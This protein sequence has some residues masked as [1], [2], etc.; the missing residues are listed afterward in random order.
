MNLEEHVDLPIKDTVA[1]FNLLGME[2]IWSCCGYNYK[3]Q[4]LK[5]VNKDHAQTFQILI[6]A[7]EDTFK[8]I[9]KI[10]NSEI[11]LW[12]GL[13]LN[14]SYRDGQGLVM[15]L[16]RAPFPKNTVGMWKAEDSPHW[17]EMPNAFIYKIN[18][19][20][21]EFRNEF[22]EEVLL[23]DQNTHMK[24]IIPTWEYP[25]SEP[26]LIKKSDVLTNLAGLIEEMEK[27]KFVASGIMVEEKPKL[28]A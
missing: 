10:F 24:K 23:V 27:T 15:T 19:R 21:M 5:I 13:N 2:T 4:D 18:A 9:T 1:M 11:F 6:S 26:W 17:H 16:M 3:D 22:A 14:I 28:I 8:K 25:V 20:L 7:K 12:Y